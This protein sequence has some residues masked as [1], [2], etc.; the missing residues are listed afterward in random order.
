MGGRECCTAHCR[1]YMAQRVCG[2]WPVAVPKPDRHCREDARPKC[3]EDF[4]NGDSARKQMF[5]LVHAVACLLNVDDV[6]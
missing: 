5:V 1:K 2:N 3:G 4:Q 6:S